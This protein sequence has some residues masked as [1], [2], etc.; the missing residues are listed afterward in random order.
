MQLTAPASALL[1]LLAIGVSAGT[2][3]KRAVEGVHLANCYI[4]D[5]VISPGVVGFSQMIYYADDTQAKNGHVPSS[6]NLCR[7]TQPN[8][9]G[10]KTWEGSSISCTFPTNTYFTSNIQADAGGLSIRKYAG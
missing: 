1:G 10:W 8:L 9:N 6:S 2:V 3:N 5:P 7:V 4:I